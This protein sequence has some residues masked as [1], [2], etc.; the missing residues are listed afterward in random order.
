MSYDMFGM[1][2]GGVFERVQQLYPMSFQ[3]YFP[4]HSVM[5][6]SMLHNLGN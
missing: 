1:H 6:H 3:N 4:P 5:S 2:Q